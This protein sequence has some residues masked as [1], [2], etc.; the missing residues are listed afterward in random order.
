[1]AAL[2]DC[3]NGGG[4]CDCPHRRRISETAFERMA[5]AAI[6]RRL[7]TDAAYRNADNAKV[8]A[9]RERVIEREVLDELSTRY[10]IEH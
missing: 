10:R 4:T 6:M 7:S 1:M 8:Q 5:D 9:E 3:S 2:C